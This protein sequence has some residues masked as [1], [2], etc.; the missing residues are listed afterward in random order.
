MQLKSIFIM[1]GLVMYIEPEGVYSL[2]RKIK[3]LMCN[4]SEMLVHTITED[5]F[6]SQNTKSARAVVESV[7]A[8]FKFGIDDP[9]K[10]LDGLG[11]F[12]IELY[13]HRDILAKIN[14]EKAESESKKMPSFMHAI[15]ISSKL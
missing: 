14:L 10:L 3:E 9:S 4:G 11:N 5:Y 6:T 15:L 8:P 13:S 12:N 7:D 2:M 1:E